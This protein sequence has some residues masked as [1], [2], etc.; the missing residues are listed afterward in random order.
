MPQSR[1][2][3]SVR[4]ELG[5]KVADDPDRNALVHATI[6]ACYCDQ[7]RTDTPNR[8]IPVATSVAERKL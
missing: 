1:V 6:L 4:R 3:S 7:P 8:N 2:G 5:I